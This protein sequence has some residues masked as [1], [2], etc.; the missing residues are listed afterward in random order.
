M[1]SGQ[2]E[3]FFDLLEES[4]EGLT[5]PGEVSSAVRC[6]AGLALSKLMALGQLRDLDR[7]EH[8]LVLAAMMGVLDE[9]DVKRPNPSKGSELEADDGA[10]RDWR[11]DERVRGVCE[12]LAYLSLHY[13]NKK[14][15]VAHNGGEWLK[16][17]IGM[18]GHADHAV[19]YGLVQVLKNIGTSVEDMQKEYNVEMQ[20]LKKL[21]EKANPGPP[22]PDVHERAG[23]AT[24]I[25]ALRALCVSYGAVAALVEATEMFAVTAAEHN[26]IL[27]ER[28]NLLPTPAVKLAEVEGA[29]LQVGGM[30]KVVAESIAQALLN[31]ASGPEPPPPKADGKDEKGE[32]GKT[33]AVIPADYNPNTTQT[34]HSRGLMVQQGALRLLLRLCGHSS[35]KAKADASLAIARIL[36][37]TNPAVL[38]ADGLVF[39]LP[40]PLVL[41]VH[42]STHELHQFEALLALTN[43]ASTPDPTLRAKIMNDG[44][45]TELRSALGDSSNPLIHRAVMETMA[46][47]VMCEPALDLLMGPSGEQDLIFLLIF[48][49]NDDDLRCALAAGGALAQ[50]AHPPCQPNSSLHH[51]AF[52]SGVRLAK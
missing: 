30:S 23:S 40:K 51:P 42:S 10:P 31:F 3:V 27:E 32:G 11:Q 45:W 8:R 17:L 39:S 36:I 4:H 1:G 14:L 28:R 6:N 21:A 18:A 16:R 47:L 52:T 43:L 29:Q 7:D 13:Q 12:T 44:A 49:Q 34:R 26:E 41:F 38:P 48:L 35:D 24:Q 9:A 19:R 37:T 25:Q 20:Q 5:A 22:K 2:A 50:V 15:L 33:K 46:N